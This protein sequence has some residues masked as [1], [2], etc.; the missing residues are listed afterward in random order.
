MKNPKRQSGELRGKDLKKKTVRSLA[1]QVHTS[2]MS[3]EMHVS[4]IQP[5]LSHILNNAGR[6]H[7]YEIYYCMEDVT[8]I[9]QLFGDFIFFFKYTNFPLAIEH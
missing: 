3:T 8:A 2:V 5:C 6:A 7:F 9:L 4:C 1:N